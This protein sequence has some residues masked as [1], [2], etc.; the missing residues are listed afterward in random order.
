M[1]QAC[2]FDLEEL[3]AV[4]TDGTIQMKD[5]ERLKRIDDVYA[6]MQDKYAF[7]KYFNSSVQTLALSRA[8]N[9]NDVNASRLLY[10]IK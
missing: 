3:K 4:T 10:G 9:V 1:L 7:A 2:S 8:K 5:D 6:D